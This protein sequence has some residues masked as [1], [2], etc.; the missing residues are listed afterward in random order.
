MSSGPDF[1]GLEIAVLIIQKGWNDKWDRA[2]SKFLIG[3]TK[4]EGKS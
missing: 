4:P 3:E 1:V 2:P